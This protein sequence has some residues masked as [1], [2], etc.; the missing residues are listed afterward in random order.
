MHL[1]RLFTQVHLLIDNLVEGQ[2]FTNRYTW[3]VSYYFVGNLIF[4]RISTKF[5]DTCIVIASSIAI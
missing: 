3:Y 5:L 2:Y 1:F 4:K